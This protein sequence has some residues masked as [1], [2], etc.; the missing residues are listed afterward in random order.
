VTLDRSENTLVG[1][2]PAQDCAW[3][4]ISNDEAA[5]RRDLLLHAMTHTSDTEANY[6]RD[7]TR[8]WL[9]RHDIHVPIGSA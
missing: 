9:A 1:M 2:C 7:T 3:R 5:V 4:T 8:K 6:L